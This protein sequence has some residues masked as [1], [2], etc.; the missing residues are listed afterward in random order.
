MEMNLNTIVIVIISIVAAVSFLLTI[1]ER[2]KLLWKKVE[3]TIISVEKEGA[4]IEMGGM[5]VV[6]AT[7]AGVFDE[8]Y[9]LRIKYQYNIS[10]FAL[11][12]S[13]LTPLRKRRMTLREVKEHMNGLYKIGN[14]IDIFYKPSNPE[15]TSLDNTATMRGLYIIVCNII[16]FLGYLTLKHYN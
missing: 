2:R 15:I 14:K 13:D 10:G 16:L 5:D 6:A 4:P 12:G 11:N 8:V 9:N 3:G 1:Y 7:R